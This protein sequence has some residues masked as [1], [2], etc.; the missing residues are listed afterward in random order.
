MTSPLVSIVIPSHDY[1]R[2]LDEAISSAC[3]QTHRPVEVIVIDDGSTDDSLEVARRHPVKVVAQA[4]RGVCMARNRGAAEASGPFL[5]CLDA[6]DVLEPTYVAACM[7]ALSE[8]PPHVAY[9]YTAMRL[10]GTV[11]EVFASRPF[12]PRQLVKHTFV[13]SSALIRTEVFRAVGGFGPT[14][15]LGLEDYE[16]WIRLLDRG[17]HGVL[18]PEPLLRYRQHG[19]SRNQL[20]RE[21]RQFLK[22]RLRLTYPRLFRRKLLHHPLASLQWLLVT[23]RDARSRLARGPSIEEPLRP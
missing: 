3:S 18:V 9:A 1:G 8:A 23:R 6:D 11:E 21:Q 10:F 17:Y 12:D 20:T 19:Q 4:N 16:L 13:N 15:T 14:W 2:F 7:T 5:M 22:W